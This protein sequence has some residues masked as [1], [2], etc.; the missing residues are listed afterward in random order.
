MGRGSTFRDL[1]L[2]EAAQTSGQVHARSPVNAPLCF[3]VEIVLGNVCVAFSGDRC[4]TSARLRTNN[5]S[6]AAPGL[7]PEVVERCRE[8]IG[9]IFGR[10]PTP[11]IGI[12]PDDLFLFGIRNDDYIQATWSLHF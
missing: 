1:G 9:S 6:V 7:T 5:R 3:K 8:A 11:F 4:A 10:H 12:P 2:S